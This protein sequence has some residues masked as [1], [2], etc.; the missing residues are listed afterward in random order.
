MTEETHRA[1]PRLVLASASPRRARILASLGISFRIAVPDVD[2]T[3]PAGE[4]ARQAVRRLARI[5][6]SSVVVTEDIPVLGADTVV[7]LDGQPVGKPGSSDEAREMLRRL[8]ERTHE[9][10]TGLCLI[11]Q[12]GL[13]D[14]DE[15]T[16]VS[17]SPLDDR[18]IEWYVASGE[19][20]DKAGAYHID[21]LGAFFI[22]SIQ[23]SPSNVAGLPVSR[24]LELSRRAGVSLGPG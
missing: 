14:A 9:V 5:K 22:Q 3:I 7:L 8:S 19:P 18:A 10:L 2:E 20:L 12:Q 11:T 15:T 21:G 16:L 17:F 1:E 4:G 24:L 23:G 6:A 13:F